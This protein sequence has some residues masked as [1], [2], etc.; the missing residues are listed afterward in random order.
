MMGRLKVKSGHVS[1]FLEGHISETILSWGLKFFMCCIYTWT[2]EHASAWFFQPNR[3][4]WPG[5]FL[6]FGWVQVDRPLYPHEHIEPFEKEIFYG[7]SVQS[8]KRSYLCIIIT[9]ATSININD[10][11]LRDISQVSKES[12]YSRIRTDIETSASLLNS[13]IQYII[14]ARTIYCTLTIKLDFAIT[15]VCLRIFVLL[16][17]QINRL[18]WTCS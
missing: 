13:F 12:S 2:H 9:K 8:G 1:R 7:T 11:I 3:R 4:G 6:N 17:K 14:R 15:K 5:K 10:R 16:L 18:G